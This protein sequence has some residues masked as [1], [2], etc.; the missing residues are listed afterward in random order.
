MNTSSL[1][2]TR[3]LTLC[4][5][6]LRRPQPTIFRVVAM[7]GL[8]AT[9]W[10]ATSDRPGESSSA[11]SPAPSPGEAVQLSPF[12][13]N[14]SRDTSYGALN[15]TSVTAFN[16]ELLKTP[17]A[18]D[19]FT[20]E[21]MRDVATTNVEDLLS[22]YGAGVGMVLRN[23]NETDIANNQPGDRTGVSQFGSRGVTAGFPRRDGFRVSSTNA[24]INDTFDTERV[25]VVKGANAMLFGASG[26]GGIVTIGS[27][28]G[29]FGRT[30]QPL[31]KASASYRIDQY[32]SQRTEL[33][34]NYGLKNLA[35]RFVL[36]NEE[37]SYRRL[38][39]GSRTE[40]FYAVL[41][42]RLPFNTTLHLSGRKTD[43]D[44]IQPTPT[45]DLSFTNATRD[46]RHNFSLP[47]LLAS[48]QAGAI[49]PST[50]IPY[51]GGAI[52]NGKLTWENAWSW[53]GWTSEADVTTANG[54]L[55]VDTVWT[56]WLSTSFGTMYDFA[57]TQ[58]SSG[59]ALLAPRAFN[60]ANPYDEWASGSNFAMDRGNT[61][62]D[63]RRY[64]Y[65]ANAVLTN[66]L[67]QGRAKSQTVFGYDHNFQSGGFVSYAY[68]EADANFRLYDLANPRPASAG[69]TSGADQLGRVAMGQ[70]YWPVGNGPVKKPY[71]KPGSRQ[72]TVGGRN[73]V[74]V[75]Q[76]PRNPN[77][78]SPLNP[79]GLVSLVPGFTGIGGTN[80]GN[81]SVDNN[82]SGFYAANYTSWL[83][84]RFTTLVGFR[85]SNTFSRTPNASTTGTEAWTET[86]QDSNS[87]NLGLTYRLKPW[88]YA[89][90]NMG[91]TFNPA[92]GSGDP[93]GKDPSDTKGASREFGLKY[94]PA[95]ARVSGSI[96]YYFAESEQENLNFGTPNRDLINPNGLNGAFNQAQRGQW[97]PVDK[98]SRG[99]EIILTAT[100][101]RNWR[102]RLGFTQQDGRIKSSSTFPMLWNDEFHY[103]KTNGGVTYA[104]GT[105]F[106]V[107]TDAAGIATVNATSALRAP[108]GGASNAQLTLAMM[109]DPASPYYAYGQGGTTNANGQITANT[110]VFRALRWFQIPS[111]GQSIQARTL[112]T[113]LPL[114]AIPYAY[115]D[116]AG[117]KGIAVVTSA[118]EP[119]VGQPLYRFVFNNAYEISEGWLRGSTIGAT[120]RWDID[121]STYYYIEPDGR[122]GNTRRLFREGNINPQVSAFVAYRR[123]I[124]RYQ[125]RTQLNVDNL[126]NR[127]QVEIRPSTV[128]GYAVENA[129]TAT[130]VGQPRLFV[131]TNSVSF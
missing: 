43:N 105:P 44:R 38:F 95:N 67:F 6:S 66:D 16:T 65:R 83:N 45:N 37:Q 31:V 76:N 124:G 88:L 97:I 69:G 40:A 27:K 28:R 93:Y 5:P 9:A 11:A 51:P 125:F 24:S 103:T 22:N 61:A 47:Y 117:L 98:K 119:T 96:A 30:G 2:F 68:Y 114:S 21:F 111:G 128:T 72:I 122:G 113:G 12:E 121:K 71:F 126:F 80:R 50:G 60:S 26:A 102:A 23:L 104:D 14:T 48:N 62:N 127:Y 129:L 74:F 13:V 54:T 49:N 41:S 108:V 57:I 73:Y 110:T 107:P 100:P 87:Y 118:G 91:H 70:I 90:W 17:V 4:I 78:V 82:D 99:L 55:L 15:S 92:Q 32:G 56:K 25:E 10:A 34:A 20:Q 101:T 115:N 33:D 64:A 94:E 131:W 89:Y 52:A 35:F 59:G 18:A 29:Q 19:I 116:P 36:M 86:D 77:F 123:K 112:R 46:P 42:A 120:A 63:G 7:C 109:S 84:E 79:L 39:I 75:Q 1:F 53:S 58:A 3:S 8:A 130:F 81:F 85:R 106:L